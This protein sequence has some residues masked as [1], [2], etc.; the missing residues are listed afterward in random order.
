MK[1]INTDLW[2]VHTK[3]EPNTCYW[4]IC[5][6]KESDRHGHKSYG[7]FGETKLLISDSGGPCKNIVS[8]MIWNKLVKVAQEV[9][10]ELNKQENKE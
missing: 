10:E 7:W 5:V 6:I 8:E 9:A 2:H 3:G 1:S 4:E